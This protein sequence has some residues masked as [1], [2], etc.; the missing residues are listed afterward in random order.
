[1]DILGVV[2]QDFKLFAFSIKD[3]VDLGT[4]AADKAVLQCIEKS[5]LKDKICALDRGIYTSVYKE[6]D[7][8]GIEFSGGEGQKL[9]IARAYFKDAPVVVLDEPT[10]ALDP[11]A[12]Y[13][14]YAQFHKLI[15]GKIT[16]YISHRLSSCQFCDKVAVFEQGTISEYG[17]HRQLLNAGG[18]YQ[19]LWEMQAQ[20]Y[21]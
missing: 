17:T 14:I 18:L 2:F 19:Q 13:E 8:H 5:G 4:D 21:I 9:A 15:D 12:E 16:I 11:L 6:F 20:Y 10:S 1:M 7:E 3:N